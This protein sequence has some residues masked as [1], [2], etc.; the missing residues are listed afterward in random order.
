MAG[1]SDKAVKTNYSENKYRFN[2]KELQHQEFADGA[3]LEEYDYEARLQDP[4]LGVWHNIDP[5]ADK[6]RRFSAYNYA[7]DNPV[8]F[9]DGDGMEGQDANSN[10]SP[11][12]QALQNYADQ[13]GMN[14][15]D[16]TTM[17]INGDL[18]SSTEDD[19]TSTAT[20]DDGGTDINQSKDLDNTRH[21]SGNSEIAHNS[22][23][24]DSGGDK[25]KKSEG[26]G[27]EFNDPSRIPEQDKKLT[28]DDIQKIK[29]KG[30]DHS[31]KP[32]GRNAPGIDLYKDRKGNV[33]EKPKGGGGYGEPIGIN[34]NTLNNVV[35]TGVGVAIGIAIY[36]GV[37]WIV[38]AVLAPET[39][40][41]SLAVA[42]A[43]P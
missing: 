9:I 24:T 16:V 4:Q 10:P 17:Y 23:K 19:N 3:G 29:D 12:Q 11:I 37:K 1:L 7:F 39:A 35:K 8:R 22:I 34:L 14:L 28:P 40:G 41:A 25:K 36:E 30:W 42:T 5:L 43:T 20:S 27:S 33:Y 6:N 26:N 21:N 18:T 2:G 13:S 32:K 15:S 31:Q 38:A